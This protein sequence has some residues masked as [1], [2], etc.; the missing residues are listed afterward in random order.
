MGS[1]EQA[2]RDL[3]DS[4]WKA[5]TD[6]DV[7]GLLAMMADDVLYLTP[8]QEPFGRREFEQAARGRPGVRIEGSSQ[9]EELDVAGPWA[10]MRT[11]IDVTMT[12]ENGESNRRS[13]HTLTILRKQR[14]GHWVLARDA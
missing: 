13:G 6:G 3:L 7:D 10:W 4:W 5:T 8:G 9:I 1:D 2:I 14:D 11:R 12:P